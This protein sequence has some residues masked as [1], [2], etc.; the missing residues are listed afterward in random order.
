MS[1][2]SN[3]I[4][5]DGSDKFYIYRHSDGYPEGAG[6]D[7]KKFMA[8]DKYTHWDGSKLATNLVRLNEPT[9]YGFGP[10]DYYPYEITTGVHGDIEYLYLITLTDTESQLQCYKVVGWDAPEE[11]IIKEENLVEIP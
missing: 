7:L 10:K 8:K 5:Q 11:D 3:I 6:K 2:R 9:D 4:I 1:T